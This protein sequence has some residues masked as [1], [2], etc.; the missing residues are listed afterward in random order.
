MSRVRQ[1]CEQAIRGIPMHEHV[2]CGEQ[3]C[4]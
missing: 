2:R 4:W 1:I 3:R